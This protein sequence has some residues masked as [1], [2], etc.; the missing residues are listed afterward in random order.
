MIRRNRG[1]TEVGHNTFSRRVNHDI[2]WLD[3]AVNNAVCMGKVQSRGNLKRNIHYLGLGQE[4]A[5]FYRRVA[6]LVNNVLKRAALDKCHYK[7]MEP[8]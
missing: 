2:G 8:V 5:G 6:T 1:Q 4:P 3:V 7:I